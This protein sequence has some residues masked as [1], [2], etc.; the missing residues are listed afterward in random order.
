MDSIRSANMTLE[1][2]KEEINL[3]VQRLSACG[4]GKKK[5][6]KINDANKF[7]DMLKLFP[8]VQWK[9][10]GELKNKLKEER[11]KLTSYKVEMDS[12]LPGYQLSFFEDPKVISEQESKE[13][14]EVNDHLER[15]IKWLHKCLGMTV[16]RNYFM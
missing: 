16:N 5:A 9:T 11:K 4:V 8:Y 15:E 10:V 1:Q 14:G 12:F 3:A 13:I 2:M 6:K 7:M